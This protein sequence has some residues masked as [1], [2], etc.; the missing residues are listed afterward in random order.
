M[1]DA[2]VTVYFEEPS[3]PRGEG[4]V[5]WI[6]GPSDVAEVSWS[7]DSIEEHYTEFMMA[8]NASPRVTERGMAI[9]CSQAKDLP[10]GLYVLHGLELRHRAG[11][12]GR[13]LSPAE[14]GHVLFEVREPSTAPRSAQDL[15]V[16]VDAILARRRADFLAGVGHGRRHYR[17]FVFFKDCYIT[18]RMRLKRYDVLP[19]RGLSCLDELELVQGFLQ[20]IGQPRLEGTERLAE[21]AR[22]G[23]P[24]AVVYFPNVRAESVEMAHMIAEQETDL[25]VALLSLQRGGAGSVMSSLVHDVNAG[26]LRYQLRA[27]VYRGNMMGGWLSGEVPRTIVAR[28]DA[29]RRSPLCAFYIRLYREAVREP[30]AEFQY[31]RLWSLL[32]MI[33]RHKKYIGRPLLAWAGEVVR[34]AKG[35]ERIIQGE[36]EEL[37]FELLRETMAANYSDASL[38]MGL[39]QGA[40]SQQVAIWYRRRNCIVHGGDCYCRDASLPLDGKIKYANCRAA[41]AEVL[42]GTD[43][44]LS[45]L[46]AVTE[47]VLARELSGP[48]ADRQSA[49]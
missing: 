43:G 11:T 47:L 42:G 14:F 21:Q 6:N 36:A 26:E 10:A 18:T 1:D 19:L 46:R 12:A 44:Y 23:H 30:H 40:L 45:A 33:A 5:L 49:A 4:V 27:P 3:M 35:H 29:L 15:R 7:I 2:A 34:N 48:G 37:V 17:V 20:E 24:A 8:A 39:R 31:F 16:A 25:L 28:M 9:D 22:S 41:R 38:A 32:E 13:K